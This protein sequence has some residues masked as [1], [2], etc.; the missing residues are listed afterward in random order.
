MNPSDMENKNTTK[1]LDKIRSKILENITSLLCALSAQFQVQSP[2]TN[3]LQPQEVDYDDVS[4]DY[5]SN[6]GDLKFM[7]RRAHYHGII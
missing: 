6:S 2:D 7:W 3:F 1:M 4:C 5:D